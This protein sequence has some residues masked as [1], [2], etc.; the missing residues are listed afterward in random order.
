VSSFIRATFELGSPRSGILGVDPA[1]KSSLQQKL[2]TAALSL[3][4][5]LKVVLLALAIKLVLWAPF[6]PMIYYT[7]L[8]SHAP[9]VVSKPCYFSTDRTQLTRTPQ[10]NSQASIFWDVVI[11]TVIMDQVERRAFGTIAGAEI[12]NELMAPF[13]HAGSRGGGSGG[14]AG[15]TEL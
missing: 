1:V 15:P 11:G 13:G 6:I 2:E 5:M 4:Y 7:W 12:F 8:G 14:D 3:V 9:T 10:K